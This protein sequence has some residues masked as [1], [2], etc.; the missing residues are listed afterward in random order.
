MPEVVRL[1]T[2]VETA[3]A[4]SCSQIALSVRQEA[5]LDDGRHIE[6]IA[7][8]G[9]SESGP[10]NIWTEVSVRHIMETA[11]VVV[12]PDE[13]FGRRTNQEMAT[14]HWKSLAALLQRQGISTEVRTLSL[15]PDEISLSPALLLRLQPNPK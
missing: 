3:D 12:G 11:R 9:W 15:L 1:L 10:T 13:P 6:V 5:V 8:R 2:L 7:G 14:E 4:C